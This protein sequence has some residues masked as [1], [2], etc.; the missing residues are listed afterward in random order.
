VSRSHAVPAGPTVENKW[1]DRAD[2]TW[3]ESIATTASIHAG[4]RSKSPR[5]PDAGV[6]SA[7][8]PLAARSQPV[9]LS[10]SRANGT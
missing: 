9:A 8:T 7:T 5:E 4:T 3:T 2:P 6:G 10:R 1:V